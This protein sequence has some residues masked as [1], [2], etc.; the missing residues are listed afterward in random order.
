MGGVLVSLLTAPFALL[1]DALSFLISAA[2]I[3]RAREAEAAPETRGDA[4]E[5]GR[6]NH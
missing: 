1:V 5:R 2:F 4:R 3:A 6:G